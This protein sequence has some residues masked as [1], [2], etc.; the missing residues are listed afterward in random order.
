MFKKFKQ[1]RFSKG[2]IFLLCLSISMGII[3]AQEIKNSKNQTVYRISKDGTIYDKYGRPVGRKK[4]DGTITDKSGRTNLRVQGQ[5]IT[6]KHGRPIGRKK[7]DGT[8]TDKHGRTIA[9]KD[10]T[11]IRINNTIKFRKQ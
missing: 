11:D 2:F 8:I 6:D 1:H 4:S 9:T 3:H 5:V 7:P 10:S